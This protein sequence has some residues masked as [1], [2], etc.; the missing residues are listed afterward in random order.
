[1]EV[2]ILNKASL[3]FLDQI[4]SVYEG[5]QCWRFNKARNKFLLSMLCT[6]VVL[7]SFFCEISVLRV[8]GC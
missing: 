8:Y 7:G 3:N 5:G 4:M 6:M 2:L 1:M